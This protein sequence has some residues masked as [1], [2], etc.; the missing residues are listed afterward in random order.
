MEKIQYVL[1]DQ[2]TISLL[3]N[4]GGSNTKFQGNISKNIEENKN[5]NSLYMSTLFSDEEK[6][7]V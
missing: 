7:K 5:L 6:D 2:K 3:I 1:A 4:G